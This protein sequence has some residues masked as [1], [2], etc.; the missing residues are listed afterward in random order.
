LRREFTKKSIGHLETLIREIQ[1]DPN[2]MKLL[3]ILSRQLEKLVDEGRPDI[4]AFVDAL[5]KEKLI[6]KEEFHDLSVS[7]ALDE[8]SNFERMGHHRLTRSFSTQD[9]MPKGVLDAAVDRLIGDISAKVLGK[10]KLEDVDTV[11]VNNRGKLSCDIFH[12][13][14]HGK[15][16]NDD[17]IMAAMDISDKPF[18][19]MHGYSVPLDR[20]G[21]TRSTKAVE[22]PLSGWAGRLA[23]CASRRET[24]LELLSVW[25]TSAHCT[26]KGITSRYSK[27]MSERK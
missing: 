11:A 12:R 23:N 1:A 10:R 22:R 2:R 17:M 4:H 27:S 8:V 16:F 20:F 15:W 9:A 24:C 13:L 19:V 3:K 18:F 7:F 5:E 21:R 26:T 25:Y 14:R 6:S